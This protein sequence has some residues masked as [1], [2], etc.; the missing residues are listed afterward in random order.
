MEIGQGENPE[1]ADN[2]ISPSGRSVTIRDVARLAGVSPGT[3]SRAVRNSPLV[4]RETRKRILE[5][6]TELDYRPNLA[7]RRLVLGHTLNIAVFTPLL[8]RACVNRQLSGV[9]S[10]L[11]DTEYDLVIHRVASAAEREK[12]FAAFPARSQVDGVLLLSVSPA[13]EEVETLKKARVPIVIVG[14]CA[15]WASSFHRLSADDFGGGWLAAQYLLDLGHEVIG[16][17]GDSFDRPFNLRKSESIR[18][19]YRQA[20]EKMGITVGPELIR[21]CPPDWK[22]AKEV[23]T[24]MLSASNR[25]TSIM[26]AGDRQAAGVLKA[27][28]EIGIRVPDELSV[29][30]CGDGYLAEILELTTLFQPHID[31]G[32][33]AVEVLLGAI[34]NPGSTPVDL[35]LPV[36]M[37]QRKTA[38]PVRP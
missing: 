37:V 12:A 33:M 23:A 17:L 21:E 25:P 11:A 38:G 30:G 28:A 20:L 26:T 35:A 5:I 14:T 34:E 27:A 36:E 6:A 8:I 22:A 15:A 7:A 9:L 31:L 16:F 18:R 32:T 2:P 24:G 4:N 1:S 29:I 19:G 3:V 13:E 10:A